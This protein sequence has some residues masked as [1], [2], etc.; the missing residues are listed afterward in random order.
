VYVY[1]RWCSV[2][3]LG[4]ILVAQRVPCVDRSQ[5]QQPFSRSPRTCCDWW[6][7]TRRCTRCARR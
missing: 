3:H 2:C 6:P 1:V 7:S 4:K 5:C